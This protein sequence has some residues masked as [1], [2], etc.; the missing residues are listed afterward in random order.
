MFMLII[1]K[2]YGNILIIFFIKTH[3]KI[4]HEVNNYVTKFSKHKKI[5]RFFVFKQ[6][7]LE[8]QK[9]EYQVKNF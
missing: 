3:F 8:F 7:V 5:A 4:T 2:D 6:R 1:L 9:L